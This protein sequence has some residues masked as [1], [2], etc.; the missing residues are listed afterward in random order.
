MANKADHQQTIVLMSR[1]CLFEFSFVSYCNTSYPRVVKFFM[2]ARA[3]IV[4]FVSV[5]SLRRQLIVATVNLDHNHDDDDVD[6]EV[7]SLCL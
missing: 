5:D 7:G 2:A 1:W 4:S 6:Y 3:E